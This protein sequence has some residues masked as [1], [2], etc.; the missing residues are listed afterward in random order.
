MEKSVSFFG[1][2]DAKDGAR[3]GGLGENSRDA[4]ECVESTKEATDLKQ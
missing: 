3:I 4:I 1:H 2:T